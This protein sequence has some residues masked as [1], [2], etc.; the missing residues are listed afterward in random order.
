MVYYNS[1]GKLTVMHSS[2]EPKGLSM[3]KSSQEGF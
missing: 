2:L 3:F 1:I